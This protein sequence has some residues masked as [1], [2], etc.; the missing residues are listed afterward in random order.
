MQRE[1]VIRM[2]R[3]MFSLGALVVVAV[4]FGVG[5]AAAKPKNPNAVVGVAHIFATSD[6]GGF[7]DGRFR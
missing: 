3:K 2:L 4:T 6:S 7:S 5:N 1:E